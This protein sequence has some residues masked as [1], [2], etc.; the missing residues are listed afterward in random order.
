MAGGEEEEG[1]GGGGG[2]E[3]EGGGGGE[4][5][6]GTGTRSYAI[7]LRVLRYEIAYGATHCSL[8]LYRTPHS[9]IAYA[10]DS[11]R[12]YACAMP[13]PSYAVCGT[14]LAYGLLRGV[15]YWHSLWCYAVCGERERETEAGVEERERKV[16]AYACAMQCP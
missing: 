11:L 5:E 3:E 2:E 6:E 10:R 13:C 12:C 1:G 4:G 16:A 15:R 9:T 7:V 8:S 14:E